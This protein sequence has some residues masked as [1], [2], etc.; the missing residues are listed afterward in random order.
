MKRS[1]LNDT[2]GLPDPLLGYNFDLV[3]PKIPG[4]SIP[5]RNLTLKCQSTSIPGM[6][7]EPVILA[8]HGIELSYAG[9]QIWSK[10]FTA[11]FVETRDSTTRQQIRDWIKFARNNSK[12]AG[13]YKSDYAVNAILYLYD[14]IPNITNEIKIVNVFPTG[15][16]DVAMDGSNSNLISVSVTLNYDWTEESKN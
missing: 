5:T 2:A 15:L 10:T 1:S 9:R 12:N 11:T 16:E 3:F 13:H 4:S 8:I 6:Q 14:D 7:I